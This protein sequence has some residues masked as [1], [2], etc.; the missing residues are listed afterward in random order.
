M[1]IS[2][3]AKGNQQFKLRVGSQMYGTST[4]ES[5]EDFTGMFIAPIDYYYGLNRVEQV[6]CGKVDKNKSGKNTKDAI[7]YTIYEFYKFCKLCKDNNPNMLEVLFVNKENIIE[8]SPIGQKILDNRH[9]FLHKGVYQKLSGFAFSQKKKMLI[10]RDNYV[11]LT[12]GLEFFKENLSH[13][14][15]Y[16]KRL[17]DSLKDESLLP[18][19]IKLKNDHVSI[20]DLNF[21]YTKQVE[22][23]M[24]SVEARI[25][26]AG[27]RKESFLKHGFDPK[28]GSHFIRLL[29]QG[30]EIFKTGNL[31]FPLQY[32]N[33]IRDIKSGKW[34]K[35][36]I[37]KY[38]EELEKELESL[39][40]SST[41]LPYTYNIDEL[42]NFM[43]DILKEYHK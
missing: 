1:N 25:K 31:V 27:H 28:F 32:A 19:C 36:D 16:G 39:Y 33:T 6:E 23:V 40:E 3:Y 14:P 8:C 26:K 41:K 4:P 34:I 2:D 24:S 5:D 22:K 30:V 38:G 42:N 11:D 21:Q 35:E 37:I 12:D 15:N 18:D 17:V 7:D 29:M 20:G 13:N 43:I 10:K 9:I